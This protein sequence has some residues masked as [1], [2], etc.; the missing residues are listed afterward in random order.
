MNIEDKTKV[1]ALITAGGAVLIKLV[2]AGLLTWFSMAYLLGTNPPW[3]VFLFIFLAF[4]ALLEAGN[5]K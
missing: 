2:L 5:K 1:V 3:Y 4:D